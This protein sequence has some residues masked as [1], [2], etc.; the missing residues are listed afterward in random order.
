MSIEID[1][2]VERDLTE[3]AGIKNMSVNALLREFTAEQKRYWKERREDMAAIEKF[4]ATGE[5]IS[6]D[7]MFSKMD[8]MINEARTLANTKTID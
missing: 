2:K 4:R 7:E 1:P 6:Q 3:L 5:G 8:R